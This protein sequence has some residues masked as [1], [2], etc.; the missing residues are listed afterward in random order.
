MRAGFR[1]HFPLGKE[2]VLV[3][4]VLRI[5]SIQ[6]QYYNNCENNDLFLSA[7]V[8]ERIF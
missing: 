8:V 7:H 5:V 2:M 6:F 3:Q 1:F 4:K